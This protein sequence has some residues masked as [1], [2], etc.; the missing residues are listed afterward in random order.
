MANHPD[1]DTCTRCFRPKPLTAQEYD[2]DVDDKLGLCARG[3]RVTSMTAHEATLE[4]TSHEA[5]VYK[6]RLRR[7][8]TLL[9]S[10]TALPFMGGEY[11]E[12][13]TGEIRE[14]LKASKRHG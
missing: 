14:F 3:S 12:R 7:A 8:E 13:V 10:A 1:R 6:L 4:C 5:H 2:E 9:N 11:V